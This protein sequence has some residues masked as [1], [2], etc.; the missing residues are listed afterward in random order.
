MNTKNI[1]IAGCGGMSLGFQ[2]SGFKIK[3]SNKLAQITKASKIKAKKIRDLQ[4]NLLNSK[5]PKHLLR[6]MKSQQEK[7]N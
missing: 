1:Y 7:V 4:E 5:Q 3:V 2:M 6:K